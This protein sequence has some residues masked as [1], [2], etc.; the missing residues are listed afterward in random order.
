MW[1]S[2]RNLGMGKVAKRVNSRPPVPN[3]KKPARRRKKHANFALPERKRKKNC[4]GRRTKFMVLLMKN[5]LRPS[6]FK[7][8]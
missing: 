4:D 7:G 2:G 8:I 5:T 6:L 1:V 3:K